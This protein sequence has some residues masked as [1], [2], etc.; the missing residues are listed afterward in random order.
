MKRLFMMAAL[1]T[2]LGTWACGGSGA[3]H[4]M[5][6]SAPN[7]EAG[8]QIATTV[9][10]GTTDDNGTVGHPPVSVRTRPASTGRERSPAG[11]RPSTT[12][13]TTPARTA[14]KEPRLQ[15]SVYARAGETPPGR[16]QPLDAP[17][18]KLTGSGWHEGDIA[19]VIRRAGD[20]GVVMTAG[21]RA[22]ASGRWEQ[23][24]VL[25]IIA[26]PGSYVAVASQG[27]HSQGELRAGNVAGGTGAGG[28]RQ[29][30]CRAVAAPGRAGAQWCA[31]RRAEGGRPRPRTRLQ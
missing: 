5:A 25:P 23:T 29:R 10:G 22:D 18:W 8:R 12:T 4:R 28:P 1:S 2:A 27:R 19:L 14:D 26:S 20:A 31:V 11:S 30:T 3:D 13:T 16:V 17:A 24:F 9:E 7:A 21:G 15:I 6:V